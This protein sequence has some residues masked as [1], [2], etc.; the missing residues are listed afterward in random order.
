[1][2]CQPRLGG[3]DDAALLT[4]DHGFGRI[5]EPLARLHL[6]EDERAAPA[7]HD[8]DLADRTAEAPRHDA[9]ALCDQQCGGAAFGREPECERNLPLG[10]RRDW[11]RGRVTWRPARHGGLS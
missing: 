4:R 8:V 3:S 2:F 10:A 6:D 9:I 5:V 7:R 11:R 1:M